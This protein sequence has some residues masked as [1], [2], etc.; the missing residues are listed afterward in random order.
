MLVFLALVVVAILL[1]RSALA[2]GCIGVVSGFTVAAITMAYA[3]MIWSTL[4]GV[5]RTI[6]VL[7][8][9]G[10]IGFAIVGF[11]LFAGTDGESPV[12]QH[13]KAID[14]DRLDEAEQREE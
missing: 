5:G 7:S 9:I 14:A 11:I 13:K 12:A 10:I 6:V 3:I 4:G 1:L 8:P 2:V